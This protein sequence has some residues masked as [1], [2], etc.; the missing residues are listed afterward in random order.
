MVEDEMSIF[1]GNYFEQFRGLFRKALVVIQAPL[2]RN[3]FCPAPLKK[4]PLIDRDQFN[5]IVVPD[6]LSQ[7]LQERLVG[8]SHTLTFLSGAISGVL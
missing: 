2:C 1:V 5:L 7:A 4:R 3:H 6:S 8:S